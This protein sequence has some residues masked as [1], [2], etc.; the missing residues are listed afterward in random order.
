[1]T[2]AEST[3]ASRRAAQLAVVTV[4][5]H[6]QGALEG[7]IESLAHGTVQPAETVVVNNA[8]GD[9]LELPDFDGLRVVEASGNLGYGAGVN[10]GVRQ[11]DPEIEWVL[12][13]NPD[14]RVSPHA[15]E[16]L[17]EI[18][19]AEPTAGAIGPRI[20]E[21]SGEV[22]PS[23]RELPSL[24]TG[25]GHALFAN[26]WLSN[27]WS[28]R[29]HG[30]Y[31]ASS[32]RWR[33]TGWL[34]GSCQLVRR[35]AFE[36]IGGFDDSYFM[37]FED[38]DLGDRLARAGWRNLYVSTASVMHSG[39]HSTKT[40]AAEMRVAHHRSAYQYLSRRYSAWYLWPLRVGLRAAL[41][42]RARV[43]RKG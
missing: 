39:A 16:T 9:Q 37:Y 1:V 43:S 32:E 6:S 25:I 34:S 13:T 11:L 27:P 21:P 4:S 36:A 19:A 35:A 5:F 3:P 26:V 31:R 22:Y 42:L 8:P 2:S 15:L 20:I 33:E 7:L 28:Q 29:Y 40:V 41:E 30:E 38:V 18:A 24:R 23:A 14:V 12:V 17:L 10:L